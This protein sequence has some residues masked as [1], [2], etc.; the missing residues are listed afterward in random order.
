MTKFPKIKL[1]LNE[2]SS[3]RAKRIE[4]KYSGDVDAFQKAILIATVKTIA[5]V[6]VWK[7][8]GK[9]RF[10]FNDKNLYFCPEKLDVFSIDGKQIDV[11]AFDKYVQK[12]IAD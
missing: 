2:Y 4:E 5:G 7:K 6:K 11:D 1:A 12:Y 10:Y 3:T 8:N 9:V